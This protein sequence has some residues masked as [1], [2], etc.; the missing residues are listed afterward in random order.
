MVES[1]TVLNTKYNKIHFKF[2]SSNSM[3]YC[4]GIAI[5]DGL[6]FLSDSRTNAGV[7]QIQ[8]HS[9]LHAFQSSRHFYVL[10]TAGNLATSQGVIDRLK[11]DIDENSPSNLFNKSNMRDAA[12]YVG[13]LSRV[14]QR[15]LS[16]HPKE[17]EFKPEASF[18]LGGQVETEEPTMTQIYSE[19]NF[20]SA[21]NETCFLQLGEI[22]YGKPIL[23]RMLDKHTSLHQ[24]LMCGLVSMDSTMKSSALVG[25]PIQYV[26][27][28]RNSFAAALQITLKE[29]DEYLGSLR[30]AWAKN[31]RAAFES[32]PLAPGWDAQKAHPKNN[33]LNIHD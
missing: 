24:A 6:V 33:V 1:I 8:I 3:T 19:G 28:Q 17:S 14:E 30:Q 5:N 10:L 11:R 23:D 13:E 7:D 31:I 26:V 2:S 21:G 20:I 25:P 22:K 15:R 4:I 18:I 12:T 9:K 29:D 27:Y 16:P 32:L